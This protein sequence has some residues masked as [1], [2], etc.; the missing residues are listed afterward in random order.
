MWFLGFSFFLFFSFSSNVWLSF[1]FRL[2]SFFSCLL[3]TPF[4]GLWSFEQVA[5]SFS[6][7]FTSRFGLPERLYSRQWGPAFPFIFMSLKENLEY[8]FFY[9]ETW[10]TKPHLW[11][12]FFFKPKELQKSIRTAKHHG[13]D[14][15]RSS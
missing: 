4:F 14:Q 1:S 11:A 6:R 2:I 13:L 9:I 15:K 12:L 7:D 3:S 10:E 8:I 5:F